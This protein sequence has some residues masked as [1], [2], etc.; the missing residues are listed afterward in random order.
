MVLKIKK[1][2]FRLYLPLVIILLL[3]VITP[4]KKSM[5]KYFL[6]L[7]F[8]T[9]NYVFTQSS[10][11]EKAWEA[12]N[13]NK[14]S[15]AS[16]FLDDA[17][18]NPATFEDAF[19][20][21]LYLDIYRGKETEVKDFS[22]TFYSKV[23]NP[24][25]YIYALWFNHAVLGTTGKKYFPHQLV[26]ANQLVK[27]K[28]A[29]GTLV[30]SANYHL[31]MHNL[32]SND[33]EK[34][35][36]F[37]EEMGGVQNWQFTG[38]F[39]NISQSG[40]Y[41]DFGPLSH[42][43]PDAI[44]KSITNADIKW[45]SPSSEIREGWVPVSN[46]FKNQT[47]TIYA[48]NFVTS[49]KDQAV[50]CSIGF[51]G[52]IKV[53]INDELIIGE[54]KE[55]V[56]ELDAYIA[57][58][59]LKKGVNRVLVQLG[60]TNN[61]YPNFILRFTDPNFNAI[62]D[63]K[64]S[65]A[66]ASY[67]KSRNSSSNSDLL[68]PFAEK[69]FSDRIAKSPRNLI[70]Y[71]LL[72]DVYLR[73]KKVVE[74]RNIVTAAMEQ[75]P[76]NCLFKLKML[77][78]LL[79]EDNRTLLMEEVEKIKQL[80]PDCLLVM[81]L[82]I[83]ELFDNQKYEDGAGILEKRIGLYG[84]DESTASYKILLLAQEKKYEELVKEI[85]R[86]YDKYPTNEKIMDMIYN[87]KKEVYKDKKDAMRVYENF[88]K[89]NFDYGVYMKYAT[90]LEEQGNADKALTIKK[91]LTERF[92]YD[93]DGFFN[94][95]EY[96]YGTKQYDKAEEYIKGSLSLSPYTEKFWEQMGDILKEKRKVA[97]AM[98]AYNKSL[99]YDPNQYSIIN[100]IRKLN[101]QPE[102]Y[103]LLPEV[104]ID[105]LIKNDKISEAKNI[106]YGYYYILDQ[107]DVI[108]YPGGAT[109]QYF[110]I[111]LRITNDKGVD[112]YKESSI[113]YGSHQTLLI[114]KAE[115]IKK[116]Q[117]RIYGERNEN[118]IVFTNLEAG[119]IIVFKYRLQNY[120]YGRLAREYWDNFYF[121]GQIYSAVSRYNLL[122]PADQQLY[123]TVNNASLRPVIT[124]VESF[125]HY[126][127]QQMK[128][129]PDKDE[130]LMPAIS[131]FA[132]V[133]HLST[134]PSWKV[135]ADWYSDICNNSAE[136]D[137]ELI[138][139]YKSLFPDAKKTMTEFQKARI[140]YDYIESNIRYSSVPFRQSAFVP[141]RPSAT[142]TTRLG[143]CKDLSSLFVTLAHM[144]G[145]NAQMVLVD[146][147]E[148][149]QKNIVLPCVEFNHCIVKAVLD[150][151]EYYIEL[152]DNYLPF[153]SLPNNLIGATILEIPNRVVGDKV[154]LQLLKG[155][156]RTRDMV[157]RV[158]DIK[159]IDTDL[160]VAVKTVK[161]G[162]ESS[163]I[164]STYENLDKE[165]QLK[166]MEES[167]TGRYKN[168][169][170]LLDIKFK[171]LDK[172][173]DSVEYTHKYRVS[174]EIAEIGAL[175]TFRVVYPDV[176]A[177][178]DNFSSDTR[179]YPVE[180][181]SYEVLDGYETVVNIELPAANKFSEIPLSENHSFK[182]MKYSIK[183]TLKAPNKLTIYRTYSNNRQNIPAS[184]YPAFKA[185]F[186]KIV[187]AEQKFIAYK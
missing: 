185:F 55:R 139:L 96:Y 56:T 88:M 155:N 24:Y 118:E 153:G 69:Y 48:Q 7:S 39:E 109:E 28:K 25:P 54:P 64:G 84:E 83:K 4:S 170:K 121:G 147:R 46:Q 52:S 131:D 44:F 1:Y 169:V 93:P 174:N 32:F 156:N 65:S 31:A 66:Y 3:I 78:V 37:F 53:W 85:E 87:V 104:D 86:L 165:K 182:E 101:G 150:K 97:E 144:A 35:A 171:D 82:K 113:G 6:I 116:N 140:I 136:K 30:A 184:D 51:S 26:F 92:P 111:I 176:V 152:T 50:F 63:I 127:W 95:A 100:K 117:A 29:P 27:D 146:T 137:F 47:A 14:W 36:E 76:D 122:I 180:Y 162:S 114:E 106:D 58:V 179:V 45:F 38:P 148:N 91:K 181:W 107:R 16:K 157:K 161:Y 9:G 71:M 160:E 77:Q 175:K 13:A 108:L 15:E 42:P 172:L 41:K 177:S 164:R 21:R 17:I 62:R 129:E 68:L 178:L 167:I 149:G 132:S 60:Y 73:N 20:S 72:A 23:E 12:L 49:P 99:K 159:P 34:S 133:L 18:K 94:L 40:F 8:F 125:K 103:K 10:N 22:K 143:D 57:K 81:D 166:E 11:Y 154:D 90:I 33:F 98:D 124:D 141:Q 134:I 151:K 102:T 115:I 70:N 112:R 138:A 158:L 89:N 5:K 123:F 142:L 135:I 186:E 145:I 75:A 110:T 67:P 128:A 183:Y 187:K 79:K 19:M 163:G 59:D 2:I 74:A 130:L 120:V 61:S 80:D 173:N 126:K 105:A 119:D 168:N 43:E